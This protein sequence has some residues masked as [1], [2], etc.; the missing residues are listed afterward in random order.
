VQEASS[1]FHLQNPG[2][3]ALI[4]RYQKPEEAG[5]NETK[6]S[7]T[8]FVIHTKEPLTVRDASIINTV[9]GFTHVYYQVTEEGLKN[10]PIVLC[11]NDL[12]VFEA[13]KFEAIKEALGQQRG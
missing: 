7:E 9:P 5:T 11:E 6:G 1:C 13:I 2:Q 3:N 12:P 10:P 8:Y 4:V